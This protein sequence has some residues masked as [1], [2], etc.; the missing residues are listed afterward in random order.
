MAL[1]G[2]LLPLMD[3][4][5]TNFVQQLQQIIQATTLLPN[6][7]TYAQR[8]LHLFAIG[9][10]GL[11]LAKLAEAHWDALAILHEAQAPYQNNILYGVWAAQIPN[12]PLTLNKKAGCWYLS[13]KKM[14][15]SGAGLVERALVTADGWLLDIE[16][17]S[18]PE[19]TIQYDTS[20][21]ITQAFKETQTA[22]VFF[23]ELPIADDCFIGAHQWYLERFGFW[24]GALGPAACW[25][26]GAAG[27]IDYALH[28]RR[29]DP[30]TLAHLAAMNTNIW[31]MRTVLE[32]AGAQCD[33]ATLNKHHLHATALQ[34]RHVIETLC[35]DTL[36][37]FARAYG[38]FPLA[39]DV[40]IN[41]RYLELDLFVRQHHSERDLE[42]LG[43]LLTTP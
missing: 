3:L 39:C 18:H 27:L 22:T 25:A 8:L 29:R 26:G 20:S 37:R 24:Q 16:L 40:I 9:Q 42:Q 13:G 4:I 1:P 32:S 17:N 36:R 28:Q 23:N 5:M 14:F 38:P 11:S 6:E 21:W 35:T 15:C 19:H 2:A 33:E 12:Q 30:H 34:V 43:I 7:V 41:Q 10:M 31:T